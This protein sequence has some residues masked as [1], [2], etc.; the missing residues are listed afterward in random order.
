M[1][2]HKLPGMPMQ[3]QHPSQL[4]VFWEYPSMLQNC[5]KNFHAFFYPIRDQMEAQLAKEPADQEQARQFS[6]MDY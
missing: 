2:P 4:W 6:K 1:L 5:E 3:H